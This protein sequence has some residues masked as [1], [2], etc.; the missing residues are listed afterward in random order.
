MIF[1]M[2]RWNFLLSGE[3]YKEHLQT[4]YPITLTKKHKNTDPTIHPSTLIQSYTN[5]PILTKTQENQ[6]NNWPVNP[7]TSYLYQPPLK[8]WPNTFF[9]ALKI[10]WFPFHS[11]LESLIVLLQ[12]IKGIDCFWAKS[13]S[14]WASYSD[15]TPIPIVELNPLL[16][17]HWIYW[18]PNWLHSSRLNARITETDK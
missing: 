11:L 9:L 12:K 4:L 6:P 15:E 3:T 5:L 17:V 18:F 1:F 7:Y 8:G 13:C 16:K 14:S 10:F 2:K